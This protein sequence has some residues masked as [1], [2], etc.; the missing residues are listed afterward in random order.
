MKE[1]K[2][3]CIYALIDLAKTTKFEDITVLN[4]VEKAGVKRTTFYYNFSS[5]RDVV[6]CYF[7][8]VPLTNTH[9]I[10]DVR[11]LIDAIVTRFDEESLFISE[12]INQ[13]IY[14]DV[15]HEIVYAWAILYFRKVTNDKLKA[16]FLSGGFTSALLDL[17]GSRDKSYYRIES[18]IKI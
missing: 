14:R 1:K 11:R 12:L 4:L 18:L 7:L 5:I 15:V 10:T 2:M 8:A 13:R 17:Y 3:L 16:S 6:R 9:Q